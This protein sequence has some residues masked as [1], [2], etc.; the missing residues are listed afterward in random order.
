VKANTCEGQVQSMRVTP[1][2]HCL[3]DAVCVL[4]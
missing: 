4:H 1:Y 3:S 2:V